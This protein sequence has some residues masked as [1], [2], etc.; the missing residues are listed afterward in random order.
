VATPT[1]L[2]SATANLDALGVDHEPVKDSGDVSILQFRDPDGIA[3]ELVRSRPLNWRWVP[4][5]AHRL[6]DDP[7]HPALVETVAARLGRMES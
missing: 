3:L 2:H 7:G 4:V 1:D 5:G 6:R